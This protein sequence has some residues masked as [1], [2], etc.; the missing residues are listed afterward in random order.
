MLFPAY[1]LSIVYYINANNNYNKVTGIAQLNAFSCAKNKLKG[2]KVNSQ[3]PQTLKQYLEQSSH[4]VLWKGILEGELPHPKRIGMP[5]SLYIPQRY[6]Q[7]IYF[8]TNNMK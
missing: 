3:D 8:D 2:C 7:I 4:L 5:Y 1:Y 6:Q